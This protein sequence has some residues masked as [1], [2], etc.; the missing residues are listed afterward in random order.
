M[1][2]AE[3]RKNIAVQNY[4]EIGTQRI[5]VEGEALRTYSR[6]I[7]WPLIEHLLKLNILLVG[8]VG[9]QSVGYTQGLGKGLSCSLSSA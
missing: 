6:L 4:F 9:H 7:Q 3:K 2:K 8:A 1:K 5:C